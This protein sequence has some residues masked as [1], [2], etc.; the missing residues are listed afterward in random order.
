MSRDFDVIRLEIDESSI[1]GLD[2]RLRNQLMGCMHAHNELTVLNRVFMAAIN[3]TGD[4]EHFDSATSVQMW[5]LMQVLAGKLF[6]TWLMVI[7]RF[8]NARPEDPTLADLKS[9]HKESLDWLKGY[10]GDKETTLKQHAAIRIIRDKTAFHYD[11]L[12][13]REAVHNLAD[14]ENVI[15]LAQHPANSLYYLGSAAVF[16]AIFALI[17]E[18]A[19]DSSGLTHGEKTAKGASIAIEDVNHA[20]FHMHQ[21]LYG[22]IEQLL[23]KAVGKPL[24]SL[25]QHRISIENAPDPDTLKLPAFIDIGAG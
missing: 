6:E 16:R 9:T 12:N 7:K 14:N 24:T 20:N 17:A 11:Q 25:P 10:F 13:L 23:E 5:C 21:V 19:G 4:G 15:Y 8:L 3:S 18:K 22:L 1:Q 2:N